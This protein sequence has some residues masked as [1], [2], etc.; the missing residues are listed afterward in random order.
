MGTIPHNVILG[1]STVSF[2]ATSPQ[3]ENQLIENLKLF[4]PQLPK[5]IKQNGLYTEN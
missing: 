1:N 5:N 4:S 3:Y 2:Y